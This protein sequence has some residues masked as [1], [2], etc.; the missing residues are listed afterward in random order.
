MKFQFALLDTIRDSYCDKRK[1]GIK[2]SESSVRRR[3][4][5]LGLNCKKQLYWV[6]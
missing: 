4:R 1:Y 3:L 6:S 2:L 5:Q